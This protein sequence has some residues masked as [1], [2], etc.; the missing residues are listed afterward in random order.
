MFVSNATYLRL[1]YDCRFIHFEPM[2]TRKG[3]PY[4]IIDQ[5]PRRIYSKWLNEDDSNDE[6]DSDSDGD[7]N[8]DAHRAASIGDMDILEDI[9]EE[10]ESLLLTTDKNGWS[11]LHEGVRAG[12][13]DIIDFLL[14][15]GADVDEETEGGENAF[16]LALSYHGPDSE[17][18]QILESHSNEH[19]EI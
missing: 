3:R 6:S 4:Y 17:V 1:R 10:D 18:L 16:D 19:D 2:V 5:V 7:D 9:L 8:L 11:P 14:E 13:L 15:H 12:H